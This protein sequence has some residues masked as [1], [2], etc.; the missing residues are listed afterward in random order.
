[1]RRL[2]TDD[3][4]ASVRISSPRAG[5]TMGLGGDEDG[6]GADAACVES[7]SVTRRRRPRNSACRFRPD[8]RPFGELA[9]LRLA[10]RWVASRLALA[11][12]EQRA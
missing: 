12:D 4:E 2:T 10:V 5:S 11:H 9:H 6:V 8:A 3:W 1:M 7:G